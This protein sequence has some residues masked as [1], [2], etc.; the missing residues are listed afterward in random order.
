M[1]IATIIGA[2]I[3]FGLVF[4]AMAGGSGIGGFIDVPSLGIVFGGTLGSML[5][6]FPARQCASVAKVTMHTLV[7]KMSTPTDE[8][9]RIVEYANLARREGLLALEDKLQG[10]DDPFFAKGI[11]LVIDGFPVET[12]RDIMELEADWQFQRHSAGRKVL[13]SAAATA[14]AFGMVGTLIGLV[15]MLANLSNPDDIGAGMSVA[16]LTTLYGAMLANMVLIPLAGKLEVRA[17]EEVLL[18]DLMVE[19]IVAIQSGEKPQL[20]KEK[21]KSFL[22]PS[23]RVAIED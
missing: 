6:N 23:A 22:A 7:F 12:V 4:Q 5:M 13:E 3:S 14:P 1:D 18:R 10:V 11:Q 20:I 16:L 15:K 21:L 17:K 19:G 2:L 8:I 9:E